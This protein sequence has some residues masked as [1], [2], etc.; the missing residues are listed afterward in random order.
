MLQNKN[1]L[2][3]LI[4]L[5]GPIEQE[6][7]EF[8]FNKKD[9]F[10]KII[11]IQSNISNDLMK[12]F[13]FNR[14]KIKTILYNNN[15]IIEL[16]NNN[17]NHKISDYFYLSMLLEREDIIDY[18]Y[19]I[20]FMNNIINKNSNDM[21]NI[22]IL[23]L[24]HNLIENYKEST[25]TEEEVVKRIE[26][27]IN[28]NFENGKKINQ[29][30]LQFSQDDLK[31]SIEEIY[32]DIIK[33]MF[34]N[35]KIDD[36]IME[37]LDLK[38]INITQKIFNFINEYYKNLNI[39]E[40][41]IKDY[42]V[43]NI[44]FNFSLFKYVLKNRI[45]LY[46]IPFFV[47]LRKK[48]INFIKKNILEFPSNILNDKILKEKLEYIL[49]FIFDSQ[50]YNNIIEKKI[51]DLNNGNISSKD[52]TK[53]NTSIFPQNQY[54]S[55]EEDYRVLKLEEEFQQ[56]KSR[57]ES[58]NFIK[59]LKAGY[60]SGSYLIGGIDDVLNLLN[61][62]FKLQQSFDLKEI[63]SSNTNK[64][65][66]EK[67]ILTK[68]IIEIES[69]EGIRQFE[70]FL[71]SVKGI[72]Y[73]LFEKQNINISVTNKNE[74]DISCNG[75]IRLSDGN[76]LIFGEGGIYKCSSNLI[77]GKQSNDKI[78]RIE[79]T[80][81]YKGGIKIE[82]DLIV[83]TSNEIFPNGENTLFL[84]DA[85]KNEPPIEKIKDFSFVSGINGLFLAEK[86]NEKILLC[87]CKKYNP[88]QK[89]RILLM[90]TKNIETEKSNEFIYLEE[91][92]VNCFCQINQKKNDKM[93]ITDYILVGGFDNDKNKGVI[94]L[95]RIKSA[96]N[97][98]GYTLEF[99][100]DIF[101][102]S[103]IKEDDVKGGFEG[104]INWII[105]SKTTRK[106][107]VS[108]LNGTAFCFSEPNID[109]YLNN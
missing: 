9:S 54:K 20:D 45:Y 73:L 102:E 18:E 50:Y 86:E 66:N 82:D 68:N 10:Q 105:Q 41:E 61:K 4:I 11:D 96:K 103:C 100:E 90:K 28:Y 109:Y 88:K 97:K 94:K 81:N 70:I 34:E 98:C 67:N 42:F 76:Y 19:E 47:R 60:N 78:E 107:L 89:N 26:N 13:Y 51:K 15:E 79:K 77:K 104:S 84:Y 49:N 83:L 36:N 23:K 44:N 55:T 58:F 108:C 37:Q 27:K 38:N 62:D 95:F 25:E 35:K 85:R 2:I 3:N 17:I 87:A 57:K 53:Q 52:S 5:N 106:I 101:F 8:F 16:K 33:N 64:R 6:E 24:I 99:L 92:E 63:I 75:C 65:I 22:I 59:E 69:E 39:N 32:I 48:I 93:I 40:K 46:Q 29:F 74:L 31:K 30:N 7:Q 72:F 12:I 1:D 14:K 21:K 91:F 43:K 71:C 56:M 80:K